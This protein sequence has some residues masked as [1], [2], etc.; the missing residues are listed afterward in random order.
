MVFAYNGSREPVR[1]LR[2]EMDRLFNGV[3]NE[4]SEGGW[5]WGG[6]GQPAVNVWETAEAVMVE[7]EIPGVKSDQVDI[8]VI[9]NQLTVKVERPASE[10][11]EVTYHRQERP[12][13]SFSRSL[14]L[15]TEV[16]ADKVE[17]ALENG[18]LTITLPKAEA[19]K[20]RK[21][22]ITTK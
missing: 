15:P 8:S 19:A 16:A 11:P 22:N 18:V 20:P 3:L 6:R 21:I 7:M 4:I 13:G 12:T 14:R 5:P 1:Q 10:E 2:R 9:G 17:A